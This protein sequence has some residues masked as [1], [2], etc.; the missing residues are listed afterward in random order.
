MPPAHLGYARSMS[1]EDVVVKP[2]AKSER[3]LI[4]GMMQT[5]LGECS[6]FTGQKAG[7]NGRYQYPMLDLYWEHDDRLPFIIELGSSVIGFA[8]LRR[9]RNA[10]SVVELFVK[11]EYR[12]CGY[13]RATTH[14]LFSHFP[15]R[16]AVRQLLMNAEG[17]AF[18]RKVINEVDSQFEERIE[19]AND[20]RSYTVQR[21]RTEAN[22]PSEID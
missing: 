16:W 15:G 19:T 17:Q 4:A 22:A 12:R 21:F 1:A 5:Y 20:G 6:A 11:P 14:A 9:R 3:S 10:T 13:G 7:G 18:W 8:L 2:A